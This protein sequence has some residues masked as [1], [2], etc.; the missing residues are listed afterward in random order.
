MSESMNAR[1]GIKT[2]SRRSWLA[3]RTIRTSKSE[4]MNARQGIKTDPVPAP[5]I[6]AGLNQ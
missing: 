3:T 6:K 1:Q 2:I 5:A 4:S